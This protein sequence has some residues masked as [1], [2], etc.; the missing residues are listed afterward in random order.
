M[1]DWGREA[2]NPVTWYTRKFNPLRDTS[3]DNILSKQVLTNHAG[4]NHNFL[5][6]DVYK[7]QYISIQE[8]QH[9]TCVYVSY[10]VGEFLIEERVTD[11]SFRTD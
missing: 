9:I 6:F 1:S 7:V 2:Q 8:L 10:S 11:N 4:I 5:Q 3:I